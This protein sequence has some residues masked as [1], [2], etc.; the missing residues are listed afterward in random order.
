LQLTFWLLD[1][2]TET[3][4]GMPELWLWGIDEAGNRVLVVDKN[5]LD[6]FYAVPQEGCNLAEVAKQIEQT[7]GNLIQ[8]LEPAQRRYFGKPVQ[9]IKIFCDKPSK[10]AKAVQ[11]LEGIKE[12]LED[13]IRISMRY[14]I[15]NGVVPCSCTKPP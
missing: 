15:D 10:V 3:K 13:D 14:L 2:N 11:K 1:I 5:F 7:C 4:A 9:A 8:K 6:Y 12:C